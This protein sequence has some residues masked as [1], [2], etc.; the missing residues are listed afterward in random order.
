MGKFSEGF[1][2]HAVYLSEEAEKADQYCT[3][4]F[5]SDID[6]KIFRPTGVA[7]PLYCYFAFVA[8][9]TIGYPVYTKDGVGQIRS[10]HVGKSVYASPNLELAT[11]PVHSI[12]TP[13][14]AHTLI[15]EAGAKSEGFT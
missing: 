6:R 8:R 14:H 5:D 1:L 3:H 7:Q 12:E 15:A 4:D 13:V 9:V 10:L 11:I 2:G